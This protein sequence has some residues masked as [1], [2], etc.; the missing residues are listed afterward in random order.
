MICLMAFKSSPTHVITIKINEDPLPQSSIE[1]K[2]EKDLEIRFD[3]NVASK[4]FN[5]ASSDDEE[6]KTPT[7]GGFNIYG[8]I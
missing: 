6:S 2:S 5:Q 8:L 7:K 4:E 3:Q 1:F